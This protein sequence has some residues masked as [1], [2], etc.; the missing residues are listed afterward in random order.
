MS[1]Y[2]KNL[3]KNKEAPDS[4]C[5]LPWS[6]VNINGNGVFRLCC[7]SVSNKTKCIL[8][9]E[10]KKP[11]HVKEADWDSVMNSDIMKSVRRKMLQGQ[12]PE[13]CI[14]C[15]KEFKAGTKSLNIKIRSQLASAVE[16]KNYPDYHK[17][18]VLTQKD[19]SISLKDFPVSFLDIRF[20]NQ[21]NLKCVMCG[22]TES[23]MWYKDYSVAFNK[24]YFMEADH[25]IK[26]KVNSNGKL[27]TENNVFDWNDDSFFLSQIEKHI[28]TFRK[29]HITGG[30]PLL[31]K[32]HWDFLRK[33]I[34]KGVASKIRIEYNSNITNVPP[35]AWD[36]WKHFKSIDM[37][38]SVDCFG[39]VNDFIRYPSKWN[40]IENNMLKFDMSTEKISPYIVTVVSILNIW[41]LPEFVFY[42]MNKNYQK[43]GAG[44]TSPVISPHPL[45]WPEYLDISIL[46]DHF[47]CKIEQRFNKFKEI[48]SKFDWQFHCGDSRGCVKWGRKIERACNILDSYINFMRDNRYNNEELSRHRKLFIYFMD[49]LDEL[50]GTAWKETLPEAFKH[51]YEWRKINVD[52]KKLGVQS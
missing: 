34:H 15:E 43:I 32:S 42:I 35:F 51:T 27:N 14:H 26:L 6:Q 33:C 31:I 12:W 38:L 52:L 30:E 8:R 4:W 46:E 17:T 21:C 37:G 49:K 2:H 16:T 44:E 47:K 29:V 24:D 7:N 13:E 36:L 3:Q 9:T 22:P 48:I 28:S 10:R 50:R 25:K 11:L 18:K 45:H 39:V 40:T 19:G 20:G 41:H 23:N 5:V 1:D